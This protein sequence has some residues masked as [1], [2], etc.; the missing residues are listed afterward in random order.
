MTHGFFISFFLKIIGRF[1]LKYEKILYFC[2]A[3]IPLLWIKIK[4][5]SSVSEYLW[6]ESWSHR[7]NKMYVRE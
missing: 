1:A 6:A 2:M 7:G 5:W 4:D 3:F